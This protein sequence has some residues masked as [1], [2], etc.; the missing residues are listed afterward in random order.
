MFMKKKKKEQVRKI[1]NLKKKGH[2]LTENSKKQKPKKIPKSPLERFNYFVRQ[3]AEKLRDSAYLDIYD[4]TIPLLI[5]RSVLGRAIE[6]HGAFKRNKYPEA[7]MEDI[8][9]ALKVDSAP[10]K[11]KTQIMLNDFADCL[12][13]LIEGKTEYLVNRKGKPLFGVKFLEDFKIDIKNRETFKGL[14]AGKMDSIE[15]RINTVEFY[16]GKTLNNKQLEIGGGK[17]FP[18]NIYLL[19]GMGMSLEGLAKEPHS[20]EI[21]KLFKHIGLITRERKEGVETAYI[22]YKSGLG[23][24]DD[25]ALIRIGMKY[26]LSA[27]LIAF[28]IDAADTYGKYTRNIREGGIDEHITN[29]AIRQLIRR[30]GESPIT[31]AEI[32]DVIYF[33][34]KNNYPKISISSSHRRFVQYEP[35]SSYPTLINHMRFI[36]GKEIEFFKLSTERM[37]STQFYSKASQR[38][39]L[40]AA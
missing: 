16:N 38:R 4:E 33:S 9:F 39:E 27:M 22:R 10:F 25:A 13:R 26:G 35:G 23:T 28:C 21:I 30:D 32:N 11:Y 14:I 36:Q 8:L 40:M 17:E 6:G 15:D 12:R 19:K 18:V 29:Q 2:V 20:Q 34:A 1:K 5:P 7:I 3:D 24:C 31:Q 37:K